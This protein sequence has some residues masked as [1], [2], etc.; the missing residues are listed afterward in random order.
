[1]EDDELYFLARMQRIRRRVGPWVIA[2]G[3][4]L[5]LAVVAGAV[6]LGAAR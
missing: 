6:L 5:V 1:M 4:V 2:A 3:V